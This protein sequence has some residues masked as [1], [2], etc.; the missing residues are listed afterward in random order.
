MS[1][2]QM[3]P[4]L[5]IFAG[6]PFPPLQAKVLFE[7][8]APNPPNSPSIPLNNQESNKIVHKEAND[9]NHEESNDGSEEDSEN[10][11]SITA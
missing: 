7:G 8:W 5:S 2:F 4:H 6:L 1:W 10:G 11:E 3:H 9:D